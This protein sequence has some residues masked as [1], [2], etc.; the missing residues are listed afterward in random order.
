LAI[1]RGDKTAPRRFSP[2]AC[3]RWLDEATGTDTGHLR[4]VNAKK[5]F[6]ENSNSIRASQFHRK[7]FKIRA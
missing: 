7:A 4:A 2:T 5:D 3:R 6:G 1:E